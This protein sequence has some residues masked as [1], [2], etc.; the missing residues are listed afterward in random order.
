MTFH[1][2]NRMLSVLIIYKWLNLTGG[3]Y[4]LGKLADIQMFDFT[5]LFSTHIT[6]MLMS[7][8]MLFMFTLLPF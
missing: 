8:Y 5:F 6:N 7:N 4:L 2:V 3:I 1:P